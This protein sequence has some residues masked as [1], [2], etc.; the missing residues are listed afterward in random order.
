MQGPRK[1]SASV[2]FYHVLGFQ[3][4]RTQANRPRVSYLT[5]DENQRGLSHA[6]GTLLVAHHSVYREFL[7]ILFPFL[8]E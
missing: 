2:S 8:A 5:R 6:Y 3:R 7:R 1:L 4:G